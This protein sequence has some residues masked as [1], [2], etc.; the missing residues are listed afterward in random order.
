MRSPLSISSWPGPPTPA[1]TR[2]GG[3]FRT[4]GSWTLTSG[5]PS[6]PAMSAA[7]G[8]LSEAAWNALA[9]GAQCIRMDSFH[10]GAEWIIYVHSAPVAEPRCLDPLPWR[11]CLWDLRVRLAADYPGV[12]NLAVESLSCGMHLSGFFPFRSRVDS[13]HSAIAHPHEGRLASCMHLF[14]EFYS[15]K[16]LALELLAIM[17]TSE[18]EY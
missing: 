3:P 15:P 5:S 13:F 18:I 12:G 9:V 8:V 16:D 7:P 14:Q 4:A 6:T 17:N 10:S 11:L 1:P 2:L